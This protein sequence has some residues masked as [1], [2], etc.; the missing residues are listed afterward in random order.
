LDLADPVAQRV[1]VAV[2]PPRGG[3]PLAVALDECLERAHELAAVVALAVLD[4]AEQRLA[5]QAQGVGVLQREQE[6][7]RAQIA[8]RR[9][10]A[11]NGA[12]AAVAVRGRA[13][14]ACLERAA[15]LVVRLARA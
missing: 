7:E 1:A 5:E 13:E 3:L 8:V 2:E 14:L 15:R 11:A 10:G 9:H 4:R 12:V 6:L